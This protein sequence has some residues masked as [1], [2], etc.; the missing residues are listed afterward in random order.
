VIVNSEFGRFSKCDVLCDDN[1]LEATASP[2][3]DRILAMAN[4]AQ[5]LSLGCEA[6]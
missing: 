4:E 6:R 3:R 1:E 2:V 5:Q